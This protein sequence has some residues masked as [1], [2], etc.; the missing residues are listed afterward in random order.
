M[1]T[2]AN[3]TKPL[4]PRELTFLLGYAEGKSATDAYLE[5]RPGIERESARVS[6]C[7]MLKRIIMR[8]TWPKILEASNLAEMRF[9]RELD[10]RLK[11]VVTKHYQ[12][13]SLG[14][15]E[16]NGTRMRATEL[17]GRILGKDAQRVDLHIDTIEI[18]PAPR[19]ED[20]P[21]EAEE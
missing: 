3:P 15:F 19:P 2:T 1:L 12:D 16:D 5:I 4:T 11:A 21:E 13:K 18:I 14:E 6:A 8:A 20:Q 9:V 7:R 10:A 17:L